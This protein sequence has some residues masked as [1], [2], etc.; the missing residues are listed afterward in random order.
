LHESRA[1]AFPL[2]IVPDRHTKLRDVATTRVAGE[3]VQSKMTNHLI[4]LN[5]GDKAEQAFWGLCQTFPPEL[6]GREW[7]LQCTPYHLRA[8]EYLVDCFVIS[9]FN[10]PDCNGHI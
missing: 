8:S 9:W 1:N 7:Q 2:P 4:F 6:D 10:A 3:C 5:T